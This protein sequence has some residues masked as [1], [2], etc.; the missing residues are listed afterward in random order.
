MNAMERYRTWLNDPLLDEDLREELLSIQEDIQEI[1]ER[2]YQDISF[3]TAGLR[4]IIQAG[5][6]CMNTYTVKLASEAMARMLEETG[7]A[8][9]GIVIAYDSRH[10]SD[11]FAREA[12]LVFCAHHIPTYLFR[13]ITPVPI[14]S[15][16]VQHLGCA[17][18]VVVT[19]SHNPSPYNGY[20]AYAAYGGQLDPTDSDLVLSHM[21]S[22]SSL[23]DVKTMDEEDALYEGFLQYI[24]DVVL[25][26]Y[27]D[28]IL[29][30]MLSP[31][32]VKRQ[33]DIPIVY[34]PLYG[35]GNVPVRHLMKEA[36]FTNVHVVKGQSHPDGDF[37]TVSA[38]NPEEPDAMALAVAEGHK[39]GAKLI[40]GTDPDS[41]RMAACIPNGAA[42]LQ[43]TGNQIASILLYYKLSI[44]QERSALPQNGLI[45][46]SVVST[47]LVDR[48]ATS[49]GQGVAVLLT[50]FRYA[51]QQV[52]QAAK[53][54]RPFLFAFEESYGYLFTELSRDKDAV[55][56]SLYLAEAACYYQEKGQT[57]LDVLTEIYQAYGH[58]LEGVQTLSYP[59]A[60]GLSTMQ[61]IM[62][63]Q[64]A[65]LPATLGGKA[66]L[67]MR[68]YRNNRRLTPS[69]IA[70]GDFPKADML[71]Y[72]LE[73]GSWAC[74]RPSG[75]E[76]KLKIYA[77]AIG[78]DM[79]HTQNLLDDILRDTKALLGQ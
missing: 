28:G 7:T 34:T 75:T 47:S 55:S 25:E 76:P 70:E 65:I 72:E 4:G 64:E 15:F 69:R 51:S 42:Y 3:G 46:R 19:A 62:A 31:D 40:I 32:V 49:F 33:G 74:L 37:P 61:A 35:A 6:N 58:Q 77:S 48:I 57:L 50:G 1:N 11:L 13:E 52:A 79:A 73:G 12:A 10:K 66:V 18:G 63:Q 16:G 53:A 44:L 23:A 67:C 9:Q 56:A 71:F 22:L 5:S 2:F 39:R 41:D 26:P 17:A 27:Y 36:G 78:A 29:A 30:G 60:D 54:G 8:E 38:P 68:D 59:G 14:L 45:T 21:R 24:D 20:K 43:L